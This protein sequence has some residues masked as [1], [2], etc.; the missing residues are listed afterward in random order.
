M[1]G[2]QDKTIQNPTTEQISN[3]E[4]SVE[5]IEEPGPSGST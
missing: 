5:P 4:D 1:E 3:E 2:K